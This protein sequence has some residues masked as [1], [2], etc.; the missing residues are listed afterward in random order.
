[1][2][3]SKVKSVQGNG[4]FES[5]H[6]LL[7]KFEYEMEDG[8]VLMANHKTPSSPFAI[9]DDVEYVIKGSNDYGS[10]GNVSKPQ[11][12]E[13]KQGGGFKKHSNGSFALSYAKDL[14]VADKIDIKD[15]L[16]TADRFNDWLNTH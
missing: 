12:G 7:Y 11:E 10:W 2:K 16:T 4:T 3:I 15:I 14:V 8:Q 6:G 1:M 5:K 13:F 9:G